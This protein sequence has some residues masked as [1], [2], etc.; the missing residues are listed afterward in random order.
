MSTRVFFLN[1][2]VAQYGEEELNSLNKFLFGQGILNTVGTSWEDWILN[3]DLRVS[4]RGAGA[5]MS[6]DV[7]AGWSLLNTTR[8]SITFKVFCQSIGVTNLA[9]TSNAT[10]SNR[11]DAIIMRV[12]RSVTP[13]IT[14][15]NVVTLQVVVGTGVSALSDGAITTAIGSDDFIRL[16]NV[17]VSN[18]AVTIVNANIADTRVRASTANSIYKQ[19][20]EMLEFKSLASNPATLVEG[21]TW[22]NSTTHTLNFYDGTVIKTLGNALDTSYFV[23]FVVPY[24]GSSAP[25][26]WL[27]CDGSAVSRSTY[28]ALFALAGTSFGA[29]DGSTTFNLPDLRART[30]IGAGTGTKV[31]TFSSRASNVITVTGLTNASNNE[32]QTGQAVTYVTSGSAIGGLVTSTV[33]YVIRLSNTTFSL[34]TTLANAQAGTVITLSSD[35]TGTQ[36]FTQTL[37]ARSRGD[38]GGEENHA[39]TPTELV[40]HTHSINH[41]SSSGG[42]SGIVSNGNAPDNFSRQ[43]AS[44]GGNQGMNIMQPFAVLNYIVKT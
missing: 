30:I 16:A 11:V 20:P 9:I 31:A 22:Y 42:G 29:G 32:F 28:S 4:Q 40:A 34:A 43:T 24:V 15:N 3:G 8:N 35:G 5:N 12:S 7:S 37:T 6:V 21:M 36:T 14:T 18:G 27:L 17:T 33:Y 23:G 39:M 2:N 13:N 10:G 26:G 25:T 44:T 19:A 41:G 1:S 38:T